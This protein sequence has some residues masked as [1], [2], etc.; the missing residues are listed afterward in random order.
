MNR[1][2]LIASVI[3]VAAAAGAI[4]VRA[5]ADTG[6]SAATQGKWQA[7]V[8][9]TLAAKPQPPGAGRGK[10]EVNEVFWY[11]CGHCYKLDPTLEG[12]KKTKAKYVEFARV[13]V[14]WG[15]VHRQ[16]ARLFYTMQALKRTDLHMVVFDTI[17]REGNI[18]AAHSDEDARASH[19][20]F[21]MAHGVTEKAFNDAY[22]SKEVA[23][24]LAR[25]E[26]LTQDFDVA[27]VPLMIVN[28][29]YLTGVSEAGSAEKLVAL[30]NDLA[31]SEKKR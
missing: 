24:N 31:A 15:P 1:G 5:C 6:T 28:G 18:L 17:H 25:A 11:G 8:N 4:S 21:F 22:D 29:K 10:V 14:V 27:S 2:F 19:R 23:A 30:I 3:A 26:K 20:T 12:W 7:G 16:H 13:P 9:Y